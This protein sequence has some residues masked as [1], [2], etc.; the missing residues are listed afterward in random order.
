MEANSLMPVEMAEKELKDP[1]PSVEAWRATPEKW[2][3]IRD[4]LVAGTVIQP[5]LF[6][7]YSWVESTKEI[8][9]ARRIDGDADR[10]PLLNLEDVMKYEQGGYHP[11]P[12][13]LEAV[14][15]CAKSSKRTMQRKGKAVQRSEVSSKAPGQTGWGA[16]PTM[17]YWLLAGRASRK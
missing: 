9:F 1:P 7:D 3:N 11:S 4:V 10:Q 17:F 13:Y 6:F 8:I 12:E 5:A 14:D 15:H 2:P 16:G